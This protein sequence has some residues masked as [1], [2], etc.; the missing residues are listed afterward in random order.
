[1]IKDTQGTIQALTSLSDECIA[2]FTLDEARECLGQFNQFESQM[3]EW[4]KAFQNI[5]PDKTRECTLKL[6][7]DHANG[8]IL[9]K[10]ATFLKFFPNKSTPEAKNNPELESLQSKAQ[11]YQL[12]SQNK[13]AIREKEVLVQSHIDNLA[14]K[15]QS[16]CLI[17]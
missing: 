17:L 8:A 5:T 2:N 6:I 15:A 16:D 7:D 11:C 1:M 4:F 12:Y 3:G 14:E 10:Y 9:R 13:T